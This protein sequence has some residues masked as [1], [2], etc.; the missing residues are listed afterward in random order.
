MVASMRNVV[1][2]VKSDERYLSNIEYGTPRSGHPEGK[3][4]YHIAEMEGKLEGLRDRGISED[5]YWKLMF[6]IHVHDSF[7]AEAIA[8]SPIHSPKNHASLARVFA[9]EFTDDEDLLNMIQLHDVNYS[10]WK[11]FE[12]TG[13]YN[14]ERFNKLLETIRDWDLFLMFIVLDGSTK[15][16]DRSKT[17]WFIREVKQK[18]KT[19]VDETWVLS[20]E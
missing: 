6:L 9:S 7:K 2:A 19:L 11:Q 4:K 14:Y 1:E 8:N 18:M 10:L 20:V 5:Q 16:K 12:A 13:S 3:V 17:A 15:G